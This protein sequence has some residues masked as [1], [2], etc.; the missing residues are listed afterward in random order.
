MVADRHVPCWLEGFLEW[1]SEAPSPDIFRKWSAISTIAAALERRVW[2]RTNAGQLFPN[3]FILL[4]GPPGTGKDFAMN[5]AEELLKATNNLHLAPQSMTSKG[6]LDVLSDRQYTKKM[7]NPV[8]KATEDYNA[9]VVSVPELGVLISSHD[10]GFLSNLNELFNCRA[11]FQE[12]IRSSGETLEI[13]K[14]CIHIVAGTQPKYL[15]EIFPEAAYGM[16]FTSR[17][18]MVYHGTATKVSLFGQDRGA[19]TDLRIKLIEDIQSISHITGQFEL[20]EAAMHAIE[21]WHMTEADNDQ[22][23]HSKLQHY[24]TRRTIHILKLCMVKSIAR[25]NSMQITDED[26]LW[27]LQTLREAEALMPQIFKEI[28]SGSQIDYIEEA[29]HFI[30]RMWQKNEK[31][32]PEHRVVHFLSSRMPA[33]QIDYVLNTMIKGQVIVEV[34]ANQLNIPDHMKQPGSRLFKPQSLHVVE[35]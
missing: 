5:P 6:M 12:R 29:F 34:Q 23:Q 14:P 26:F 25:G 21:T 10:L 35:E 20:T 9:M 19:N 32:I 7:Q 31:P 28:S 1:T 16:G 4:V 13:V 11:V 17:V 24:N 27:S 30:Q 3:M 2:I 22:P 8:T 18:I 33:N 15:G